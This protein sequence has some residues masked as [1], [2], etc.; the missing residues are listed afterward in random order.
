MNRVLEGW[1]PWDEFANEIGK[2]ERT[3][4]RMIAKREVAYT[5]VGRT[6][7][8]NVIKYRKRLAAKEI[9]AKRIRRR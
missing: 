3:V 9:D 4:Q 7:H 1:L 2:S 5:Y 6:P 8:I